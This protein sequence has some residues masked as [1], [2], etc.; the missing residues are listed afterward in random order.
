VGGVGGARITHDP[1]LLD[2]AGIVAVLRSGERAA[3]RLVARDVW[4]SFSGAP[5]VVEL[6][7]R[8]EPE[9]WRV[10]G[11]VLVDGF[12]IR[13]EELDARVTPPEAHALLARVLAS[14]QPFLAWTGRTGAGT[15]A[16]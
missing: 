9:G 4:P 10:T 3:L 12:G 13:P 5:E 8:C 6:Y 2:A 15:H 14:E 16:R 11:A 7:L 1:A